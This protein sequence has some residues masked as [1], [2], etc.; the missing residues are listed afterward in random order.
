MQKS[1][2]GY[3]HLEKW[4]AAAGVA[5]F[6]V[7]LA[8]RA[9]FQDWATGE[10][11]MRYDSF[12]PFLHPWEGL[13]WVTQAVLWPAFFFRRWPWIPLVAVALLA[14]A[15]QSWMGVASASIGIRDGHLSAQGALIGMISIAQIGL[16][17]AWISLLALSKRMQP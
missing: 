10:S 8:W 6:V 7:A 11:P 1:I 13:T 14:A 3:Q 15:I 5:T 2:G 17:A 12:E 4:A 9:T 16:T